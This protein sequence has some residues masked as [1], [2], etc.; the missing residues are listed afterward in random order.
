MEVVDDAYDAVADA[1]C[2]V[3]STE[4]DEFAHL[5]LAKLRELMAYP[6][7]VDARNLFDPEE[8]AQAGFVYYPTGRPRS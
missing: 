4:W 2:L 3:L 1:H 7:V 6:V 8:M 5:D